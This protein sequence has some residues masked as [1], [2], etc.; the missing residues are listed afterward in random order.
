MDDKYREM[1]ITGG[2]A[3]GIVIIVIM[4]MCLVAS[5]MKKGDE[6]SSLGNGKTEYAQNDADKNTD[7]VTEGTAGDGETYTEGGE[8]SPSAGISNDGIAAS[9]EAEPSAPP[10]VT[11]EPQPSPTPVP[12]DEP[13]KDRITIC[14]DAAHQAKGDSTKEPVGPGASDTRVKVS[15][16]ATGVSSKVP[17]GQL[18]LEISLKLKDALINAG[19]DV[20]MI[21]ENNDVNI[22]DSDRAKKANENADIVLHIH[23]NA[24]ESETTSGV[25]AFVMSDSNPY[26]ASL[27]AESTK[28][29]KAV[30][31]NIVE[32]TGQKN[33]GVVNLDNLAELN[34]SKI[35]AAR[36]EVGYMSNAEEDEKLQTAD[37]QNKIVKGIVNGV[38]EYYGR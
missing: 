32:E 15:Y 8:Q 1:A 27:S 20:Y 3:V 13:A 14:I 24:T 11:E 23:A 25:M 7:N 35:P 10:E 29:S 38:N 9:P 36:I 18:T 26:C 31:L 12:T 17:E 22:A 16:G 21:R 6:P 28:L 34:Y 19:Y 33:Q 2:I 37:F 4:V 30:T 5:I